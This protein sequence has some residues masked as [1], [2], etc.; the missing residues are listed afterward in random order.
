MDMANTN[1]VL[2]NPAFTRELNSRMGI[3]HRQHVAAIDSKDSQIYKSITAHLEKYPDYVSLS[4]TQKDE[5][6]RRVL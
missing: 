4:D 2:N 6:Y 3:A 5:L 1:N